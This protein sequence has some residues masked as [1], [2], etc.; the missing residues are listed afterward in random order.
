MIDGNY[1]KVRDLV[2]GRADSLVW[3]DYSFPVTFV[4]LLRRTVAR[5]RSGDE[6][7]KGNRERFVEQFLS[8]DSLLFWAIRT[9]PRYR[10]TI[11]AALASE[12]HSHIRLVRLRA[13]R[14]AK[15]WLESL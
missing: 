15:R 8:Q 2:W 14:H 5:V 1:S 4:R 10:A 12:A 11:P 9:Y 13:P 7:W 3:L 6:L